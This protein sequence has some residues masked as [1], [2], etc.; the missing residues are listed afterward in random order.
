M[1]MTTIPEK[2]RRTNMIDES[3]G[4]GLGILALFIPA[5]AAPDREGT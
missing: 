4:E 2:G 1:T 3:E 5:S